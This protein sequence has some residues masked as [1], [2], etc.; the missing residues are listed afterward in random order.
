M[1]IDTSG[2]LKEG[3]RRQGGKG[4]HGSRIFY[5]SQSVA[6]SRRVEKKEGK[7]DRKVIVD[8]AKGLNF[9]TLFITRWIVTI[10]PQGQGQLPQLCVN[11]VR[12]HMIRL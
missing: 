12:G 9:F 3:G 11:G 1:S 7:A 2:H 5:H 4:T 10:R 8:R 6:G